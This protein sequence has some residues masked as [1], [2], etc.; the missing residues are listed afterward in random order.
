MATIVPSFTSLGQTGSKPVNAEAARRV[1]AFDALTE[2]I[3]ETNKVEPL[4]DNFLA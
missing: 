2:R 3:R 4:P 1:A